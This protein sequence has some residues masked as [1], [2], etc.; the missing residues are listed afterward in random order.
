MSESWE[1]RLDEGREGVPWAKV[2]ELWVVSRRVT[3]GSEFRLHREGFDPS[4]TGDLLGT[5]FAVA[6]TEAGE[7]YVLAK[8][9]GRRAKEQAI[10]R[11]KLVRLLKALR[12]LRKAA[13]DFEAILIP[14]LWEHCQPSFSSF[15]GETPPAG[16][17]TLN[18]LAI[19]AM[20][21]GLAHRGGL[22]IARML[23]RQLEPSLHRGPTDQTGSK[24]K[25]ASSG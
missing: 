7:L 21:A 17:D 13:Q 12:K 8:S 3:P 1:E 25:M 2:L 24:I 16:S 19:Q 11:S 15:S 22:G 20:S 23:V 5:G 4:A 9:E 6:E 10:R 18:S 14:E